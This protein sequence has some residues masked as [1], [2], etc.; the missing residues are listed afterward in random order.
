MSVHGPSG[1]GA[2]QTLMPVNIVFEYHLNMPLK[3][4]SHTGS[5]LT[6][7]AHMAIHE[8]VGALSLKKDGSLIVA[9]SDLTTRCL[10]M[11]SDFM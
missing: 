1:F 2:A 7:A 4:L 9:R 6:E 3:K 10:F 11:K 8:V 5:L